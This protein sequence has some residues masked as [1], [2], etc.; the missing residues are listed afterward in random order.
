M[1]DTGIECFLAVCHYKTGRRAAEA[2]YITQSSL[3]TRL[4]NLERELGGQLFYRKKGGREMTLT[5]AGKAFYALAQQYEKLM[6][7]MR[8][9]CRNTTSSL[10][11]SSYNSLGTYLLPS[12]YERFLQKF[13]GIHLQIQDLE[14]EPA[15]RSLESGMTDLAFT[16][17]VV[18]NPSLVQTPLFSEPMVLVCSGEADYPNTVQLK[19]MPPLEEVYTEW[20]TRFA[21]WHQQ[22][23]GQHSRLSISIMAHLRQYMQ[24]GKAWAIVPVSVAEGLRRDCGVRRLD[25]DIQLP[26]RDVSCLT[27]CDS[28]N[29]D[30][31][32]AFCRCLREALADYPE[33]IAI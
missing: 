10:R 16:A 25:T 28:I 3:T 5:E 9:V 8:D 17:G 32:M 2:L 23:L 13:P 27:A 24:H 12:V 31:I 21:H 14:L 22:T 1:T 6:E 20:S 7:Q 11:V 19:Q 26:R 15:C 18:N 33:I 4:K 30:A 29:A